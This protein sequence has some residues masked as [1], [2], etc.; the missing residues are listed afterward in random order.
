MSLE[1]VQ[2]GLS[3]GILVPVP[4]GN[5]EN[6]LRGENIPTQLACFLSE[7][8]SFPILPLLIRRIPSQPQRKKNREE[9]LKLF[10]DQMGVREELL[11]KSSPSTIY[12]V[13]DV[14]TTGATLKS[15]GLL[16]KSIFPSLSIKGIVLARVNPQ[17]SG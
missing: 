4:P 6:F 10:P 8:L 3:P 1:N 12:L 9:R 13:D 14:L 5:K 17:D 16:L 7:L 11:N 15:A 2:E